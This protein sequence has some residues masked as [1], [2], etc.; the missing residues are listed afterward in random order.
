MESILTLTIR[1]ADHVRHKSSSTR[2]FLQKSCFLAYFEIEGEIAMRVPFT[3]PSKYILSLDA[4]AVGK[5]RD[6][7]ETPL[8][9]TFRRKKTCLHARLE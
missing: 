7:K 6:S 5:R 9:T 1:F 2:I 3:F 4:F 8:N